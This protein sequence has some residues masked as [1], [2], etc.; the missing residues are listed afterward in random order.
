MIVEEEMIEVEERERIR[1]AFF[2]Q[3]KSIRQIARELHHSRKTVRK[4]LEGGESPRYTM[5][6]GRPSPVLGPYKEKIDQMLKQNEGLPSKQ[7]YTSHQIFKRLREEGYR[8]S[9]S[10]VRGY[11]AKVRKEGK[12][13]KLFIPLEYDPGEEAQMDWGEGIAIIGGKEEVVQLFTMRLCYSRKLF[14][15]AFPSQRQE[16]FF[17]GHVMAFH[18]FG[19]V[20][21]R[22]VYD[23]LTTA[24]KK[25]LQ[26]HNRQEQVAF[27]A[28]RSHY[29][30]ESYFCSV[31]QAHQ[32]GGVEHG[33]GYGRRNFM[34]PPP[35]VDSFAELNS[36]LL[37]CCLE[38]DERKV[39]G[40]KM[41]IGEAWQM[42]R[43][44]LLPLPCRDIECCRILPVKLN[45]YSQ[46]EFETN[47]YSVPADAGYRNLILKAYPF[48]VEILHMDKVIATHPRCYE[49][50]QDVIDPLHY[51]PL[52]EK[53]PGAFQHAKPI[54]RWRQKW[55]KA[56]ERL[57]KELQSRWPDGRGIKEFVGILKLHLDHPQEE[58]EE[59]VEMALNYGCCH[60]D[61]VK[62]CLN[63]LKMER[64]EIPPVELDSHPQLVGVG[65]HPVD[66]GKYDLLL[67]GEEE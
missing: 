6:E 39:K 17:E 7:R 31:R 22:I 46:V 43:E 18:H 56:Y 14:M 65:D 29:L 20:P 23:N 30:F 40:Q 55:P 2:I 57:L 36:H 10:S 1:R 63:Q 9:E 49:K 15:M 27:I 61:G 11:V 37:R 13:P 41:R 28:F 44:Y 3:N 62:L 38:D 67:E 33:V 53:R 32:K 8:G 26:G 42:E 64:K 51:L 48:R 21:H 4:A 59:A 47:R 52:L 24:V 35:E 45:G 5:K 12:K 54:R 16:S 50:H 58:V 25:I 60:L 34:T 19:G 66:L